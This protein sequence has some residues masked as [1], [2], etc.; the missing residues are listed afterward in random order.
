MPFHMNVLNVKV[1]FVTCYIQLVSRDECTLVLVP[2][3]LLG[4]SCTLPFTCK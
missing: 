2:S 1:Y 3:L 4:S